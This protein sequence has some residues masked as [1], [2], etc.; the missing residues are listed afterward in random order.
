[1]PVVRSREQPPLGVRCKALDPEGAV[2][3]RGSDALVPL[4]R[5]QHSHPGARH[6]I[7]IA[8]LD[9]TGE[10]LPGYA[11]DSDVLED[12]EVQNWAKE[13]AT[14]PLGALPG[15]PAKIES[16]D[17]L[18]AIV[19][20]VIF[21]CGPQHAAVNNGQFDQYGFI[22]NSPG[23]LD[24]PLPGSGS[25]PTDGYTEEMVMQAMPSRLSSLGQLGMA[26]VLSEPTH[27]SILRS[28]ECE[29]FSRENSFEAAEIVGSFRSRLDG[30]SEKI[31]Q[32]NRDLEVPYLYLDPKNIARSTGT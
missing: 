5:R 28:G 32:R 26:W 2:R 6:W 7:A 10:S 18:I 9:P 31:Y 24:I 29:A 4:P 1:M 3:I 21:R 30:I 16:R 23:L 15:F 27:R 8:V 12:Y 19:R 17:Q 20:E 11:D 14:T 22:P 25:R 13:I